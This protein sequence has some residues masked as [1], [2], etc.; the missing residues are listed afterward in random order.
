MEI[1]TVALR[2]TL[3]DDGQ[4]ESVEYHSDRSGTLRFTQETLPWSLVRALEMELGG[5]GRLVLRGEL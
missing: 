1:R 5:S 3:G 4:L 2:V